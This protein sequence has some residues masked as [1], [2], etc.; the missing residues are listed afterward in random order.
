VLYVVLPAL[1]E[2]GNVG[3]VLEDL[4]RLAGHHELTAVLVDDGSSDGTADEARAAAGSLALEVLSHDRPL[5]PGRA[6]G[7]AFGHLAGRVGDG[8]RV[9]TLEADNTSRLEIVERMLQRLE[10]GHDVA[11]ASP[12]MYGGGIVQTDQLRVVLSHAANSFVKGGLGI[13]GIFTMSSFYRLRT[14]AS[15]RRMQAAWGPEVLE[16]AGFECMVEELL[17]MM[18]L[19]MA[20]A[21]VPMVLDTSRRVGRSKMKLFRTGRGYLAVYARRRRWLSVPA[22]GP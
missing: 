9:L 15:L 2:A 19:G 5:G 22:G 13:R 3:R 14:G 21:E 8:D 4:R 12:Y 10:E 1:N 17:K 11:L 16:R 7:T 18:H 20:I 6:F